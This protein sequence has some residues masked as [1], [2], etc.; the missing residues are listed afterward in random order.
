MPNVV[1]RMGKRNKT[2]VTGVERHNERKKERYESN[3]YIDHSRTCNNYHIVEPEGRYLNCCLEKIQKAGCRMRSNSVLLIETLVSASRE[4][5][6]KMDPEEQKQYFQHAVDFMNERVGGDR[7]V[8]AVVHMD[9]TTPHMHLSFCPITKDGHLN[10]Q[11]I[12]GPYRDGLIEWQDAFFNYMHM[13]YPTLERHLSSS[14]THRRHIPPSLMR[15]MSEAVKSFKEIHE[16]LSSVNFRNV[17][18]KRTEALRILGERLPDFYQ[19]EQQVKSA[20]SYV[21]SLERTNASLHETIQEKE[22]EI[23]SIQ[24]KLDDRSLERILLEKELQ[25]MQEEHSRF[26]TLLDHLKSKYPEEFKEYCLRHTHD[27]GTER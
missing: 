2:R 19:L 23:E 21:K 24:E 8:S 20:N 3:P 11:K 7:I 17:R 25:R 16:T 22:E 1:F 5:L 9:E 26:L 18:E 13:F 14:V 6:I 4:F 27:R 15:G 12:I 10:A